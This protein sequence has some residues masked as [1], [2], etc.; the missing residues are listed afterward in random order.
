MVYEIWGTG[1]LFKWNSN[2][3]AFAY[4]VESDKSGITVVMN[5]KEV[6]NFSVY[7]SVSDLVVSPDGGAVVYSVHK[8]NERGLNVFV[9]EV[10]SPLQYDNFSGFVYS[11]D[12][13]TLAYAIQQGGTVGIRKGNEELGRYQTQTRVDYS[14]KFPILFSKDWK[15]F[16]YPIVRVSTTTKQTLIGGIATT[17]VVAL[18]DFTVSINGQEGDTYG[19][20]YLTKNSFSEDGKTFTYL[21][22]SHKNEIFRVT[23]HVGSQ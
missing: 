22:I 20:V 5:G 6:G 1:H 12:S 2:E 18:Q 9:N 19:V 16:A 7:D 21:A 10:K 23:N 15:N 14:D 13:K 4:K 8:Q 17:S 11:P 3:N